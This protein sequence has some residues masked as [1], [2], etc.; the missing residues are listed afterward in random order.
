MPGKIKAYFFSLTPVKI[1][2]ELAHKFTPP[3]FDG[4]SVYEVA[5]FFIKGVQ[6]GSLTSRASSISFQFF[7][8]IFP[9]I[10]FFFTL[11]PY[12]P[13]EDFQSQLMD[14]LKDVIPEHAYYTIESTIRD[15]IIRPRSGLL[16]VGFL[17]ALYFSTN[18]IRSIVEA[19]NRT[20]HIE[21]SRPVFKQRL[22][23]IYLVLLLAFLTIIAI[24]LITTGTFI[25]NVLED[26][27][28]LGGPAYYYFL[29]AGKWIVIIALLYFAFSSLYYFAPEKKS[30]YR[31]FSAGS[32]L[33][34]LLTLATSVDFDFYVSNF[35]KYNA[36]Y[37]SIGTLIILLLWIYFNSMILLIGF[38]LNASIFSA[39]RKR[40]QIE[41]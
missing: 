17:L 11:I 5:S 29:Q 23:A 24:A 32:T 13:V 8:A 10:L 35:S 18:G 12:I 26:N 22:I 27:R 37:G 21:E 6:K 20:V 4:L 33:A 39:S 28:I 14:L 19:F 30:R 31:F 9:A 25:I 7:L 40:Q 36:L 3:G 16:S 38:E 15:I 41:N 1:T 34:T 2:L